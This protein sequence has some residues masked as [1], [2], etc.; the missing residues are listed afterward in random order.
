MSGRLP[1]WLADWLNVSAPT[2]DEAATWE[3]H[4]SW[5]WAPWLTVLIAILL[6]VY[7]GLVYGRESTSATSKYRMLLAALR[8][9]A[10]TIV[11]IMLAQW[12]LAVRLTG[13]PALVLVID[14]SASMQIADRYPDEQLASRVRARLAAEQLGASTRLN[15]AKLL[16]TENDRGLL[17]S[18]ADRYRISA[19]SVA[20]SIESVPP[21]IEDNQLAKEI[22]AISADGADGHATRLGDALRRVLDDSPLEPP[23]A[24][25]LFSDGVNTQGMPFASAAQEA[26]RR[27]V[28]IFAVGI[29]ND[30]APSDIEVAD[31]LVD[32]AVF[33]GDAVS[34][35]V[36][37]KATGLEGQPSKITL[38]RGEE[39][40]PLTTR[41]I[42]LPPAGETLA[43]NLLHR[44]TEPGDIQYVVDVDQADDET[45]TDNNLQSRTVSVRDANIRVLLVFGYPSYE[46]RFLKTLLERDRSIELSTF[47]QDADPEFAAQDKTA[48]RAF[49]AGREELLSYDV[50]IVGDVEPK[51]L[52]SSVWQTVRAFVT[53]KG[54]GAAF[55]AGPR[56]LPWL[57]RDNQDVTALL[58]VVI[59]ALS[60]VP[61]DDLP[62]MLARGFTAR[63]TAIG[64]QSPGFQL[65]EDVTQNEAIWRAFAP[66]YWLAELGELKPAAQILAEA[67]F[68]ADSN[69]SPNQAGTS[70]PPA[71]DPPARS[72]IPLITFQYA[73]AGR[74]LFH[75]ID[76]TWRWRLGAG[77]LYFGRYWLQTIR[78]LA[79]G[80]LTS[81]EGLELTAD[82]REYVQGEP[83][84]LRA[85]FLDTSLAPPTDEL[86]VLISADGQ[87]RERKTLRRTLAADGVFEGTFTD[88][89][90]GRYEALIVDVKL[91]GTPPATRFS[92]V[93]PPGEMARTEM[94]S[95]ALSSAAETTRG[96]FYTV[97]NADRLL[98][99][100][101]AGRRVPI[102][103][104]PAKPVWNQWWLVALFLACIT[105]EW[106][107]RKRKG[108]L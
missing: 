78:F 83:V 37:I 89:K 107:M 87:Q 7:V 86:T 28:P 70:S 33:V 26:R 15:V 40:Q 81:G 91:P 35:Q 105:S 24:I 98:A 43:V 19:Y 16:V 10:L 22:R 21:S 97:A 61:P 103:N 65:G 90:T 30:D 94:D 32:D 96:K 82:R 47:L 13:P 59:D 42:V 36:Q 60:S 57:Y 50:L 25:L 75:A 6:I 88:L 76:S 104:L 39:A 4:T 67:A 12:A 68:D 100:L 34:F 95:A 8:L 29:G 63:P 80:K 23:A 108:M 101:P 18:L 41:N 14:R 58:P 27:G 11:L 44:P 49:P 53:E 77:D 17:A 3:L 31:V 46:L 1:T 5:Q 45:N 72:A 52:P 85:R 74:V 20:D 92:V 93:T 79:R 51:L 56:F 84:T 55:I 73:G 38:R 2:A 106:I 71:A 69:Y 54:G 102:E 62:P 64:L 66:L 9:S 99:D 48:L